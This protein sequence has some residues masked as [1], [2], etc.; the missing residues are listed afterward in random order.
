HGGD[1]STDHVFTIPAANLVAGTN[2]LAV[3]VHQTG[4]S[5]SDIVFGTALTET[6]EYLIRGPY[7]QVG[8]PNSIVIRWRT[9]LPTDSEVI[10]GTNLSAL[11]KTNTFAAFTN[12]H[13]IQLSGLVA[14]TRYFYS[15][16]TTTNVLSAAGTN[17][18]FITSPPSGT[19][20]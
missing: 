16:G 3:E 13:E 1:A 9:A 4:T 6:F 20:K 17:Q 5:S 19:P 11:D 7:L 12:E 2:L 10:Y 8:A 18:Y 14:N 15:I